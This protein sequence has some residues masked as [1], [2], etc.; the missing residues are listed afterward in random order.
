MYVFL[1][2]MMG[3]GFSAE[4]SSKAACEA[5]RV[6]VVEAVSEPN[7]FLTVCVPKDG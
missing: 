5:A 3:G 6:Q 1:V 4:F 7:R 2:I